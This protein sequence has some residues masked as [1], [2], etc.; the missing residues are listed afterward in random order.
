MSTISAVDLEQRIYGA[1]LCATFECSE[2]TGPQV[3]PL[4]ACWP[5]TSSRVVVARPEH[6][7]TP[8]EL[9]TPEEMDMTDAEARSVYSARLA[10]RNRTGARASDGLVPLLEEL[11]AE[12][13]ARRFVK[14]VEGV[15]WS[16]RRPDELTA[17]IDLA[18]REERLTLARRLA[19]LGRELFPGYERIDRAARVLA[20]GGARSTRLPP[21][22]GLSA[23]K[24]WLRE[25]GNEYRGQWVAVRNGELVD[26][27]PSLAEMAVIVGQDEDGTS[28]L[29][30]RVL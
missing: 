15:D 10:G 4:P 22:E 5:G 6:G 29:V 27:A 7:R 23:S 21:A 8:E 19:E 16:A 13:S 17:A 26:V 25:H 24:R 18:L 2:G 9:A 12:G 1:G 20:P 11:A 28:L 14:L 3:T 30:T